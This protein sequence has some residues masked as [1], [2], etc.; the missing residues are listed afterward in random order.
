[1]TPTE[2]PFDQI[3]LH[4]FEFIPQPGKHPDVA[5]LAARELRFGRTISMWFEQGDRPPVPYDTGASSLFVSF[6]ANA[7]LGC[8]LALG[9][10]MPTKVLDLSPEFRCIMNGRS[11]LESRGLIGAMDHFH[12]DNIGAKHKE[13]MQKRILQ[14]RPFSTEEREQTQRYCMS[15]VDA[16]AQLLPKI[17]P[18]IDLGVAL[19]RGESVIESAAMEHRGVPID[20]EVFP[21]LQDKRT[22]AAVRDAMVPVIDAQYG[23]YVRGKDGNWSF[24]QELF[25]AYLRRRGINNWPRLESG[26]LNLRRKTFENM[27]RGWPELEELRHARDKMRKI[28]LAVGPDGRNRT[29]LWPFKAKTSRTQPKAAEWIFSPAVW[30]RS[31]IK[32]EPGQAVSYIDYSSMEFMIAAVLSNCREMLELYASGD[33]YLNFAKRVGAVPQTATS[34]S[35][36]DIRD[37]YKVLLLA[38]QYGMQAETLAGRLG[39][40][41]FEA[42]E[43]LSQHR[44][45]FAP[46]WRWSD[47]WL[48]HALDSGVMRTVFDWRCLTGISEFNERSIRNWPVQSCGAEILRVACILGHRHGIELLAPVHDAVLIGAPIVRIDADTALMREIMRRA[49]RI[50]LNADPKGTHELRTKAE[51]VRYPDRY[52]D[53]RGAQIWQHVLGLLAEYEQRETGAWRAA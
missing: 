22:W 48:A 53:K 30:L 52:S 36:A 19:Y 5:C 2:L 41:T 3:W 37:K 13:Q 23:V 14:G 46:Y 8:H 27:T 40:S 15:D 21:R 43:L 12:I 45:L 11:K 29:V 47:D 9:W 35:H 24:N 10:P 38:T 44:G 49:S 16:L 28:K 31:L 7:E 18:L 4:D 20:M 39:V 51:I 50:V 26:K 6:V 34:E 17:L 32:P 33:P 25:E 1:V 42:D